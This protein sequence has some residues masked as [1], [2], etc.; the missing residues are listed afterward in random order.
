[1]LNL[2]LNRPEVLDD[3]GIVVEDDGVPPPGVDSEV[4]GSDWLLLRYGLALT[5]LDW[6]E[7]LEPKKKK[8][9]SIVQ[10]QGE[11]NSNRKHFK[12]IDFM[13]S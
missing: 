12:F 6:E 7:C 13:A 11:M 1:M 10:W 4:R 8:L 3:R 9:Y 5:E 2:L